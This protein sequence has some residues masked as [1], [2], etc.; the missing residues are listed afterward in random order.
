MLPGKPL[1]RRKI[2]SIAIKAGLFLAAAMLSLFTFNGVNV[3]RIAAATLVLVFSRQYRYAGGA[4][5][6]TAAA[7]AMLILNPDVGQTMMFYGVAGMASV[8]FSGQKR[9]AQAAMFFVVNI[10]CNW[11][12]G[13]ASQF[14]NSYID[15]AIGVLIFS[16]F[17]FKR[18]IAN[19]KKCA[20]DMDDE[21]KRHITFR[22]KAAAAS[23]DEARRRVDEISY[24]VASADANIRNRISDVTEASY[25]RVSGEILSEQIK[26]ASEL[27]SQMSV[28]LLHE[29]T[30][31]PRSAEI[32]R[33]SLEEND[34]GF[35]SVMAYQ[36]KH[37]RLFA[38]IYCHKN[39]CV[40][41]YSIYK[42]MTEVFDRS[43]EC[44]KYY[45]ND[46]IR[47][48]VSERPQ[49]NMETNIIQ[50]SSDDDDVNGDT[51]DCFKDDYGNVYTVIS[52]G[53]GTGNAAAAY[54]RTASSILKALITGGIDI[55]QSVNIINSI[56]LARTEGESFATLDIARFELDTGCVSL[57]K[58]GAAPTIY[59][60]NKSVYSVVSDSY[61]VGIMTDARPCCRSFSL[62]ANDTLAMFS[63]GVPDDSYSFIRK[64]LSQTDTDVCDISNEICRQAEKVS[65]DDIS[66]I[67]VKLIRQKK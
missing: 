44:S 36:N 8:C 27:I 57:Y 53:M 37:G 20:E 45:D 64:A 3:G 21:M 9:Y 33:T 11:I 42:T 46:E 12:A 48:L 52:D 30:T 28:N 14:I 62:H 43:F 67:V 56:M 60:H 38:E 22:M 51:C 29:F 26:T 24:K 54:S 6:G 50:K 39:S 7:A 40:S 10:T 15:A 23:L 25:Q 49:Y 65:T 35:I 2:Y 47:Y 59:S 13:D 34:I 17:S 41:G 16:I 19:E 1:S 31:D 61:P 66:V 5:A 18:F 32:I 58:N 4:A 63:D 55:M